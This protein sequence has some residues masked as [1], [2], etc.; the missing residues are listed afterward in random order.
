[1][2][3]SSDKRKD[4]SVT[5]NNEGGLKRRESSSDDNCCSY[6]K[7]EK[8]QPELREPIKNISQ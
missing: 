6:S 4:T 2:T 5:E 1:M 3:G 8:E 7:Y